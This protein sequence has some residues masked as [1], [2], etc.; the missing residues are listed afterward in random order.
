[1]TSFLNSISLLGHPLGFL[2]M[3]SLILIIPAIRSKNR[4]WI[5]SSVAY[6]LV[7]WVIT[8]KPMA[9]WTMG[10]L[11]D[12]WVEKATEFH[13]NPD[14]MPSRDAVIVLGGGNL[15][16]RHGTF[17]MDWLDASDR[18]LRGLELVAQGKSGILIVSG[19]RFSDPELESSYMNGMKSLAAEFDISSDNLVFL[20]PCESTFDEAQALKSLESAQLTPSSS[21][22]LVTS[23]YHMDRSLKLFTKAGFNV[24]PVPCDFSVRGG[25]QPGSKYPEII[26]FITN[27]NLVDTAL[28]EWIGRI[29]YKLR[30]WI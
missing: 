5:V 23:A 25:I 27:I 30:G 13:D 12:P 24:E 4:A 28:H 14:Q 17:G 20:P 1:M 2:W 11:E 3:L 7:F 22:Y 10:E 15:P 26:P 9:M 19:Y 29:V 18:M 6:A 8:S 16:S 21:Y